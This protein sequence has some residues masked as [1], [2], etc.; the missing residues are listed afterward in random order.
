MIVWYIPT[1]L[2]PDGLQIKQCLFKCLFLNKLSRSKLNLRRAELPRFNVWK[3][4]VLLKVMRTSSVISW[5]W[6]IDCASGNIQTVC[7]YRLS[8]SATKMQTK[9][10]NHGP[11]VNTTSYSVCIEFCKKARSTPAW[12]HAA[13]WIIGVFP[14]IY[15]FVFDVVFYK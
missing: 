15:L 6:A 3:K 13:V 12:T 7:Q 8:R 10:V 14:I 2:S 4:Q 9:S 5:S 1:Q 11:N